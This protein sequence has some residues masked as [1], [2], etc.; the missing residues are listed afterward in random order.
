MDLGLAGRAY[1]VT[2]GTRGLGRAAATA[3]LAE[4]ASVLV[5]ARSLPPAGEL[6]GW[7]GRAHAL[8]ADNADPSTGSRLVAS[9]LERFGRLDG[10][11]VS[12]GGPPMGSALDLGDEAW[13]AAFESVF[14]GAVRLARTV[15][16]ELAAAGGGAI[17]LVLS[18]SV[19][20]P[21]PNLAISNGFR[22]GLAMVA[23]DLA[24]ELGPSGVRVLSFAPGRINTERLHELTSADP[25]ARTRMEEI[26][27]LRRIAEPEEFG[28]VAA[29]LLSPAASYVT[30]CVI[31]VDGGM[32][33]VP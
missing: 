26:V 1:I 7:G 28:R 15:G 24:D 8:A 31:P 25:Q 14:L 27:P 6:A 33:R 3:L 5:T 12:V 4:G 23:K 29:F 19:R 13:R 22:P 20:A 10:L 2:G 9:A 11:L 17:G 30:G 21:I 32:L 18:S 16:K